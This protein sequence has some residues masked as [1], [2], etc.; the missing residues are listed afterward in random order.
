[1][2]AVHLPAPNPPPARESAPPDAPRSRSCPHPVRHAIRPLLALLGLAISLGLT[3]C[4]PLPPADLTVINGAEP[5]SLDPMLVTGIE[6]LRT[7]LPL[8]GGLTRVDASTGRALPGLAQRWEISP[9]G[10]SYTFHLRT[11][12]T[13]STGEPITS[14]DVIYSWRRVLEPT[15]ACQYANLLFPVRGAE[16]YLLGRSTR[17]ESVG[18]HAPNPHAVRVDLHAPCAFFLDLCAF[19][20]LS[21]VPRWTIEEH[22]DRWILAR[23]L[24]SSGPYELD[25]WRLNDRIRL[26]RNTR[27][28]DTA[29]TRSQ[30]IDLL[31]VS[32]PGTAINLYLQGRADI[33]WD[34]P[35]VPT[36]LME[37]LARTPD[38]HSFPILG[39]FFLRLN[40][41][42]KPFDDARVRRAF[43]LATDKRRLTQRITAS[44]EQ[45]AD[46]L[47]P[48]VTANYLRGPGQSHNPGEARRLLTEA[49]FPDG[50]GFPTVD[51]FIDSAAGGAAR[52]F[53]RTGVELKEMWEREL[54]VR[55]EIRRMEK[56]TFLVA[57]RALEYSISRSSWIGDYNDP[58]TFLDLFMTSNGN[59]RTGWSNPTYDQLLRDAAAEPRL[60]K[61]AAILRDAETLLVRDEAPVIPL[62]FEVGFALYRPHRIHGAHPNPLDTHPFETIY[63]SP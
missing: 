27:Y 22:G 14:A 5:S 42:R 52:T 8:F 49:G 18:L 59:N 54:G 56:K 20:T 29:N 13:W 45:P 51:L 6:E 23:P 55:V 53:E 7:V 10:R 28:W 1:M 21:V 4:H 3:A 31:S 60:D 44:G 47:V 41:T 48:T 33:L 58:N 2:P 12:A 63:R 62:W 38:F 15:N 17:F 19:Q 50:R 16:D 32:A 57:Q 26:R 61:R 9:D 35:L 24:P 39:T 46:H 30:V 34:K 36:E 25:F 11:N 37:D 40:V 43:A